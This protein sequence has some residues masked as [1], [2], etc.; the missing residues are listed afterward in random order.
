M[1][2]TIN[3][4]K[5]ADGRIKV[6]PSAHLGERFNDYLYTTRLAGARFD[7]DLKA[8]V[9]EAKNVA[10]VIKVLRDEKFD[11]S[12]DVAVADHLKV[13][14]GEARAK[15][16]QRDESMSVIIAKLAKRGLKLF[17]Y[18][19][20][21]VAWLMGRQT[22]LLADDMGLGKTPQSLVALP[23]G[24]R[25]IVVCPA[26]I[27][28]NWVREAR[29]WVPQLKSKVLS[30]RGS[31]RWPRSNEMVIINYDILP[32]EVSEAPQNVYLIAD[33]AHA[34]KTSTAARTK[35]FMQLSNEVRASGGHVWLLTGTPLLNRPTELWQILKTAGLHEKAFGSHTNFMRLFN[36]MRNRWGGFDFTGEVNPQVPQLLR[37]V[38]LHRRK[39]DVLTDLPEKQVFDIQVESNPE[40]DRII[41]QWADKVASLTGVNLRESF[42]EDAFGKAMSVAFEE[43]S[44]VRAAIARAKMPLMFSIVEE[45][46]E[47]D[48]PLIVFSFHRQPIDALGQ[49]EGWATITGSTSQDERMEIVK[50]F[51][52]GKYKGIAGTIQAMGVGVTLTHASHVLF[53]DLAWT[54]A[55]NSQAEDRAHRIGQKSNVMIKRLVLDNAVEAR[56]YELLTFKQQ[57]IAKSVGD[58]AVM[59]TATTNAS[60]M[61]EQVLAAAKVVD[62]EA[63]TQKAKAERES[64]LSEIDTS[65][66]LESCCYAVPT[67]DGHLAFYQVDR[68]TEGKWA[69]WVFVKLQ[70]GPTMQRFGAIR[71]DRSVTGPNVIPVLK[72]ILSDPKGACAAYGLNIGKCGICGLPLTNEESRKIG[73]GPICLGKA[74]W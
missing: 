64:Q 73:I 57:I 50:R 15:E 30:G 7:A 56:V 16:A 20:T 51:Q 44:A 67:E 28:H 2:A 41:D 14:I 55:L 18:Q 26:T 10:T 5:L 34:V 1:T 45:Y 12:V 46:E 19:E 52:E 68:P 24:A 71:P 40:L 32:A 48:E 13:E 22:A 39:C 61:M 59:E 9:C 69:G 58:S 42:E 29:T 62:V 4:T 27:K 49:R 38:S 37:E 8:Q 72:K 35:K 60:E 70:T 25:V 11:V 74:G 6:S 47:A 21:G 65:K 17:K 3:I 23:E 53:V 36:G 66:L 33:E 63:A 43:L 31:F 54:P